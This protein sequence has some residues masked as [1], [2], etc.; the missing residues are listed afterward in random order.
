[1]TNATPVILAKVGKNLLHI[2]NHP[3]KMIKDRIADYFTKRCVVLT[4]FTVRF[5]LGLE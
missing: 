4:L 2:P 3:L 1:M 5:G